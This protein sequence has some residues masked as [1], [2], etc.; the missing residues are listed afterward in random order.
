MTADDL[1][2]LMDI[3]L[4]L[5]IWSATVD[6]R[7]A[8]VERRMSIPISPAM[9]PIADVLHGMIDRPEMTVQETIVDVEMTGTTG[10]MT[11][12][13]SGR[14]IGIGWIMAMI[15]VAAREHGVGVEAQFESGTTEFESG[16]LSIGTEI[17]IESVTIEMSIVDKEWF[18]KGQRISKDSRIG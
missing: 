14:G 9:D 15:A 11:E 18:P 13:G 5:G 6:L 17:M 3:G 7:G 1:I 16:S 10:D 12:T 2:G 4:V 8:E